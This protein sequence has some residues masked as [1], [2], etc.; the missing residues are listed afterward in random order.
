[1]RKESL[2]FIF[3]A[4]T[5]YTLVDHHIVVYAFSSFFRQSL[6]VVHLT[7]VIGITNDLDVG[8]R[9]FVQ[10]DSQFTQC[11]ARSIAQCT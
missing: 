9:I 1:M 10:A 4:A 5:A 8:I 2:A 7:G 11:T 6:V 3:H